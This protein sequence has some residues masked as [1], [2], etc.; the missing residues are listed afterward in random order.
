MSKAQ[1]PIEGS[2]DRT[3]A[4]SLIEELLLRYVAEDAERSRFPAQP[5]LGSV[6]R[7]EKT[8]SEGGRAYTYVAVRVGKTWYLTG[9][10][11]GAMSWDDLTECIGDGTCHL[12]TS[13]AEIPR[14]PVDPRDEI[15]DPRAWFDTVYPE[16]E[17]QSQLTPGR[18]AATCASREE[19]PRWFSPLDGESE[20]DAPE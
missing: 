5:P 10:R 1:S 20:G 2:L 19:S 4:Q 13:Y 11:A 14:L 16:A 3:K 18:H 6:L 8:Y 17:G 15:E 9:S 7:F 12:V